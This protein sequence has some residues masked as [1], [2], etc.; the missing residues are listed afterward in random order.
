MTPLTDAVLLRVE[1]L[2]PAEIRPEVVTVLREK[3]GA[4]L[5]LMSGRSPEG[6]DRVRFAVLKLSCGNFVRLLAAVADAN[7]D[8]RDTIAAAG[9]G[10]DE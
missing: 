9:L 6:F 1:K 10:Q 7:T 8:P 2:F 3:C 4:N 5:P